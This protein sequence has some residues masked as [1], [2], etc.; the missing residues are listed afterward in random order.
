MYPFPRVH[1]NWHKSQVDFLH[2]DLDKFPAF[3]DIPRVLEAE[4][5]P[6]DVLFVPPNYWH[7]VETLE[8]SVSVTTWSRQVSLQLFYAMNIL[9]VCFVFFDFISS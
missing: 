8:S 3:A 2:P 4:L 5:E 6:G 9:L 7:H 1:P